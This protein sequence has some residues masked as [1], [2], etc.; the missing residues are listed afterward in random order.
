MTSEARLE[1]VMPLP[2]DGLRIMVLGKPSRHV[3]RPTTLKPARAGE[4]VCLQV[5]PL[6]ALA[7]L[8]ANSQHQLP[9]TRMR[10]SEG[11]A[12][13]TPDYSRV[14]DPEQQWFS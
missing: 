14:R 2:P 9:A 8:R 1:K 12:Q 7:E 4:A 6:T 10:H 3:R 11:S 13:L 5:L